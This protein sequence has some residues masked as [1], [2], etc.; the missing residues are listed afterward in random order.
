MTRPSLSSPPTII[1][2]LFAGTAVSW[3]LGCPT[4]A[5]IPNAGYLNGG[6]PGQLDQICRTDNT[7]DGTLRCVED[8]N[9]PGTRPACRAP[10][11][12][13]A[14][15]CPA[16]TECL[17]VPDAPGSGVCIPTADED[18]GEGSS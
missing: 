12:V 6:N 17:P 16:G 10:C 5:E 1:A 15:E 8:D 14:P 9:D 11:L 2:L 3:L 7:C 13:D 4:G 18:D